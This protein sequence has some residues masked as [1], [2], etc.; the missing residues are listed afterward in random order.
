MKEN[1]LG[2]L[3]IAQII[4]G[5]NMFTGHWQIANLVDLL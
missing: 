4:L 2:I 3:C 5:V 1:D